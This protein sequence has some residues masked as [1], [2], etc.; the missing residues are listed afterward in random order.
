[1]VKFG[2]GDGV[3][4]NLYSE[5]NNYREKLEAVNSLI[6]KVT[7]F[8][9]VVICSDD[10][11][12]AEDLLKTVMSFS[13]SLKDLELAIYTGE[14]LNNQNN[15]IETTLHDLVTKFLDELFNLRGKISLSI[16][17]TE[18]KIIE[19]EKGESIKS[20]LL[21]KIE[22]SVKAGTISPLCVPILKGLVLEGRIST[23]FE[24]AKCISES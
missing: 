15:H 7:N 8:Y 14:N 1:M 4:L 24:L 16:T 6:E 9:E 23:P 17:E 18:S 12:N 3:T 2:R 20:D 10:N 21:A 13:S 5:L 22:F 11:D 19:Y